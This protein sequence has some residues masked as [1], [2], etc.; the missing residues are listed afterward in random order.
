MLN[1]FAA[2]QDDPQAKGLGGLLHALRFIRL[3]ELLLGHHIG[4]L[5][6]ILCGVAAVFCAAFAAN[7][8]R[9]ALGWG[10]LGFFFSV[11]TIVVLLAIPSKKV[12]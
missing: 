7:R 2:A 3:G 9:S 10:I 5:V 8:G 11:V 4:W 12:D 1:A 6:I